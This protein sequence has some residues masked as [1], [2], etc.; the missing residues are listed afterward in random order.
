MSIQISVT[1]W[2]I[3]CF[4]ILMLV[5]N[6]LLFRPMLA[7][8]DARREKT[9][10]A[11]REREER[12]AERAAEEER[13]LRENAERVRLAGEKSAQRAETLR[14][15]AHRAAA[16]QRLEYA[17]ALEDERAALKQSVKDAPV[18]LAERTEKISSVFAGKL[19]LFFTDETQQRRDAERHAVLEEKKQR[20]LS[21]RSAALQRILASGEGDESSAAGGE[22]LP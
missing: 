17:K 22:L 15:E 9:E 14:Q 3:I 12:T 11:R 4:G 13:I 8:M 1:I 18:R 20:N 2:T 10:R 19:M 21:A 16:Q 6:K 5:L 7:F